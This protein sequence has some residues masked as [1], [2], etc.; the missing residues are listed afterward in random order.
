MYALAFADGVILHAA[1]VCKGLQA[2]YLAMQRSFSD[3]HAEAKLV[4]LLPVVDLC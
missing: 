4:V 2:L 1:D 3:C